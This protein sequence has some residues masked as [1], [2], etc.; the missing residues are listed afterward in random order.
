[1]PKRRSPSQ[2][3][4]DRRKISD[5]YLKGELQTDIAR[6]LRISD[7]TV[8]RDLRSLYKQWQKSTLVDIDKK[9]AEELAKID[10]L[11]REYWAA[12]ERSCLDAET[13]RQE[14]K[15]NTT[16]DK[17][18]PEKVIKTAIGQA[19]DP[20]FLSGIQWCIERR[21]KILGIDAPE[22]KEHK[23]T[24]VKGLTDAQLHAIIEA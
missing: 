1:M 4:R 6:T 8:S 14:A 5:L 23:I 9:K 19:G 15:R 21:C 24:D 13:I 10:R 12:W 16:N 11:E 3:A 18:A 17:L 7:A 20:R 22:K 2:I